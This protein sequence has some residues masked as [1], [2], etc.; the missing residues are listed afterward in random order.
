V[1]LALIVGVGI[2][3]AA[4]ASALVQRRVQRAAY[5]LVATLAFAL[6]I[7]VAAAAVVRGGG[8]SVE[9]FARAILGQLQPGDQLAFFHADDR[10]HLALLFYL[11]HQLPMVEPVSEQAPCT[12]PRPGLFLISPAQWTEQ[13]CFRDGGW[14]EVLRGGPLIGTERSQWLVL[15]RYAGAPAAPGAP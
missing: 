9:P 14:T 10:Q 8:G 6:T 12:P 7:S 3:L 2:G 15:A 1:A 13:P 11:P 4:I 5:A